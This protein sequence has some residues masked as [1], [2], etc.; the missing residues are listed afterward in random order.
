MLAPGLDERCTIILDSNYLANKERFLS[1]SNKINRVHF[2]SQTF[3]SYWGV[4]EMHFNK[5]KK[6]AVLC[7]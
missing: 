6:K 4:N 3:K 2:I 1:S 5:K 7:F